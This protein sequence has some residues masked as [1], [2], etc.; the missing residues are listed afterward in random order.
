MDYSLEATISRPEA[1]KNTNFIINSI[2]VTTRFDLWNQDYEIP[3]KFGNKQ[4]MGENGGPGGFFH[5][6][7]IVPPI[8]EICGDI[9]NYCPN[10][11]FINFSNPI[12]RICLAIKRKFPSLKFVGLCHEIKK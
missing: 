8:L 1:L 10:A 5:S 2:E 4:I 12:S 6:L 7:R 11:L 9:K 3:R